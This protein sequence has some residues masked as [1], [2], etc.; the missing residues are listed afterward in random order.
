[1]TIGATSSE[2][3]LQ[4]LTGGSYNALKMQF[5]NTQYGYMS[6]YILN[7]KYTYFKKGIHGF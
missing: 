6:C 3:L 1:M 5:G 7:G 4:Q 2:P